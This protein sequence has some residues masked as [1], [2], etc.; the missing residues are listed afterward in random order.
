MCIGVVDHHTLASGD[1]GARSPTLVRKTLDAHSPRATRDLVGLRYGARGHKQAPRVQQDRWRIVHGTNMVRQG[2]RTPRGRVPSDRRSGLAGRSCVRIKRNDVSSSAPRA[3]T[4]LFVHGAHHGGWC[5]LI[6]MERLARCGVHAQALD[7]PFTMGRRRRRMR[8]EARSAGAR[9]TDPSTWCVTATPACPCRTAAMRA[10]HLTYVAARLPL[11]GES[12]VPSHQVGLCQIP[13]CYATDGEGVTR[14]TLCGSRYCSDR[15]D[16]TS[17]S[18]RWTVTA[19]E[20]ARGAERTRSPHPAW[21]SVP[22]SYVVC[23]D[24]RRRTAGRAANVRR[25]RRCCRWSS[26]QTI[27]RSSVTRWRSPCS[28]PVSTRLSMVAASRR[29][30]LIAPAPRPRPSPAS[31]RT[32]THG[33]GTSGRSRARRPTVRPARTAGRGGSARRRLQRSRPRDR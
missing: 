11:P 18:S 6:V 14:I 24:D 8:P 12:R 9:Q 17:T 10:D 25:P 2:A 28:S 19:D 29:R 27:R 4:V 23:R 3:S 21:T 33:A 22:S 20:Q 16:P 1:S 15:T 13:S 30:A 32:P 26:T 5:W 7:L 31:C